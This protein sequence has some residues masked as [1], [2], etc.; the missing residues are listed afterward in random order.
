MA[1]SLGGGATPFGATGTTSTPS[2]GF[3]TSTPSTGIFDMIPLLRS[4]TSIYVTVLKTVVVYLNLKL[5]N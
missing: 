4:R 3:G 5:Y 1:F 2:F